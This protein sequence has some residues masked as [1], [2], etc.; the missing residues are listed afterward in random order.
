[1]KKTK[2]KSEVNS[3]AM[4]QNANKP[5]NEVAGVREEPDDDDEFLKELEKENKALEEE[6]KNL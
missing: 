1:M 6:L 2:A 5:N 3:Q 4:I